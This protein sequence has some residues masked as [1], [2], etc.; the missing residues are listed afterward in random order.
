[1]YEKIEIIVFERKKL[2]LHEKSFAASNNKVFNYGQ[3]IGPNR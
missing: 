3:K 2:K 1:M